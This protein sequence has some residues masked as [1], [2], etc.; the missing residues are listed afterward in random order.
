MTI[1][2]G[3]TSTQ[4]FDGIITTCF[5]DAEGDRIPQ[6]TGAISEE[7]LQRGIDRIL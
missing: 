3:N 4:V 5:I 7:I 6:A 1:G 2:I